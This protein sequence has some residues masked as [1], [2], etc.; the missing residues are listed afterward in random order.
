MVARFIIECLEYWVREMHVDG[1]RFDLASAL[2]RD[3]EGQPLHNPPLLW[4]IELS[5][6]L[7]STK[8]IAEAWDAAGLYQVGTFPG[9]RWMEWNGR[10][11]DS[12]RRFVCGEPGNLS[13]IH[14]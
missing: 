10:Y 2:A 9:Y 13:L 4:G 7:A 1:F 11:R 8:I 12:L 3:E 6:V 14:I 5:D